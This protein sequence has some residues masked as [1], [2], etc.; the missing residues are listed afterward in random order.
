MFSC[1][2]TNVLIGGERDIHGHDRAGLGKRCYQFG[3][4]CGKY[5]RSIPTETE[6]F[7][8]VVMGYKGLLAD[9]C[10]LRLNGLRKVAL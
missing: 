9:Q 3:G 2:N 5:L 6:M 8:L 10:A 4:L 7:M 1:C